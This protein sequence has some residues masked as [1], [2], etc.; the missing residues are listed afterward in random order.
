MLAFRKPEP[1]MISASAS[2]K[3]LIVGSSLPA[4]AFER[5]EAVAERQQQAA[6]HHRLA[7]PEIAVG[8]IAAEH[9]RDVDQRQVGAVDQVRLVVGE[10]PMLHQVEDQQRAHAVEGEALPHLGEEQHVEALRMAR[11]FRLLARR[12]QAADRQ[13]AGEKDQSDHGDPIAFIP[14]GDILQAHRS[15]LLC[16]RALGASRA[17]NLAPKTRL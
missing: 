15:V 17:R 12:D 6:E 5:H 13:E 7:L 11:E 10:R 2:Q 8:E 4:D 3:T 1:T 16:Y 14:Q 9:R